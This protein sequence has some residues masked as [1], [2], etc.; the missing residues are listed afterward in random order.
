MR[1]IKRENLKFLF[2]PRSVAVIGAS[3]REGTVGNAVFQNILFG[4][5]TGVV[6]PV[7][8]KSRSIL[9]VKTYGSIRDVPD[10]VDLAVVVVPSTVVPEVIE[11][12]G[13]KGVKGAVVISAGFKEVGEDGRKLEE[14]VV[15]KADR[16]NLALVGPNCV[17]LVNTSPKINLNGTFAKSLPRRGKISFISQSGALGVAALEYAKSENIGLAKFVSVGNK[18]DINENDFLAYLKDDPET[19]VIL[20]YLEDLVEHKEFTE[21]ARQ[22]TG[23][24]EIKKP[25]IAV[26]SG[27][28]A[29]GARASSSHTGALAGS[30]EV[31]DSA[32]V[33]CGVLRVDTMEELFDYAVAFVNQPLP[34]GNRVAIVTNAGGPGIIATDTSVR[35]GMRLAEFNPETT[36]ILKEHL[37]AVANI[38]NPVDI[39]G[40]AREDRYELAL[41]AVLSDEN[42]DGVIVISTR[43]MMADMNKIAETIVETAGKHDKPVLTCMMATVTDISEAIEI[44]DRS[45]IPNFR[46]PED[47]ARALANMAKYGFWLQRPQTEVVEFKNVNKEKVQRVLDKAMKEGRSFLPEPEAHEILKAYGFPILK[48]KLAK[49]ENEALEAAESIGYPVVLKIVSPD[50]LHKFDVGGVRLGIKSAVELKGAYKALMKDVKKAQP[51]AKITGAFVQAMAEP[52][53]EIIIG[54]NRDPRFG[55]LLMFGL[56]GIYVE[57]LKDVSFRLAPIR[58]LSAYHMIEQIKGY[59]MLESFRGEPPSDIPSIAECLMRLSQLV[60][61]FPEII[62]LDVNPLFVY[63]EGRGARVIDA[64]ILLRVDPSDEN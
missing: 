41:D 52:G 44:L 60:M 11:E 64:R 30:D 17:G 34:R 49:D 20:L 48:S 59:K 14:E 42:V 40:D 27:R 9:G 36:R 24:P 13:E 37:P 54:M 38:S 33:Q 7:N 47:A 18:A 55:P 6:Y 50:I 51:G 53:K 19:D 4:R 3:S 25:I 16:Y 32:F 26:K 10:F 21:L 2:E 35:I 29:E 45:R 15:K 56:G 39:I 43:Q 57:V 46:F 28:T 58:E 22:I 23:D 5:Y 1:E 62:E 63:Q 61:D 8:P 31:Y 12:C